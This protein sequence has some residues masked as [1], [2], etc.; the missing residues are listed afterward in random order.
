[1]LHVTLSRVDHVEAAPAR[2]RG[3]SRGDDDGAVGEI[4][5]ERGSNLQR[6][7]RLAGAS[8][9]SREREPAHIAAQFITTPEYAARLRRRHR[10]ELE[11]AEDA[12]SR[13]WS[14]KVER[15]SNTARRISQ[16]LCEMQAPL[17]GAVA[18]RGRSRGQ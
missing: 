12:A 11:L 3:P 2:D 4:A 18:P 10:L 17:D 9:R 8:R 1:M 7:A 5:G 6:E 13:G 14:H 15:H 16:L